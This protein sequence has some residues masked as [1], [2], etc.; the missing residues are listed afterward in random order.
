MHLQ[1]C[2]SN[3]FN[4][5]YLGLQ[6]FTGVRKENSSAA[7]RK[8]DHWR[9]NFIYT[10]K[11]EHEQT[12]GTLKIT[13]SRQKTKKIQETYLL[14]EMEPTLMCDNYDKEPKT[15]QRET[16]KDKQACFWFKDGS[17]KKQSISVLMAKNM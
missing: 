2:D 1:Q 17:V 9:L 6:I 14:K 5:L 8:T 16:I 13:K 3:L 11:T 4:V 10:N 7:K 15:Q 12:P